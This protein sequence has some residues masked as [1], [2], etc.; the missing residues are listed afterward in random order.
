MSVSSANQ[1]ANAALQAYEQGQL[2]DA[3]ALALQALSEVAGDPRASEVMGL[4]CIAERRFVDAIRYL[5]EGLAVSPSN[6]SLRS[7]MGTALAGK[8]R[9]KTAI[10]FFQ[11]AVQAA[12]DDAAAWENLAKTAY[13][14]KRW[15]HA[16]AAFERCC[17]I[18]PTNC[19][20]WA[21]LARLN[22]RGGTLDQAI[23][24]AK[25]ALEIDSGHVLSQQAM[26]DAMLQTGDF[27]SALEHALAA[28]QSPAATA[29]SDVLSFGFAAAA[30]E[31]LGKFADAFDFYTKMNEATS[32][33]FARSIERL[34]KMG[35]HEKLPE[36]V[37]TI[38][39]VRALFE[40]FP[41]HL[42]H[43][44]PVMFFG[45]INSGMSMINK[46]LIRHPRITSVTK[47]E[48]VDEW[49]DLL[50]SKD[51]PQKVLMQS[52]EDVAYLREHTWKNVEAVGVHVPNENLGFEY[53]PFYSQHIY[54][55]AMVF[56]DSKYIFMHRDPRDVVLLSFKRRF[57]AT[58]S[59]QEFL[60]LER[61]AEYYDLAMQVV[62]ET[63]RHFDLDIIDVGYDNIITDPERELRRLVEFLE[64]PWDDAVLGEISQAMPKVTQAPKKWRQY[65]KQLEPV[66]PLLDKWAKRFG[67]E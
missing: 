16:R 57:T 3:E 26:A 7:L 33:G 27:D 55:V 67:Y 31:K 66:R 5:K 49:R 60:S 28:T 23:E 19:D 44:A 6:A 10:G 48:Y 53:R 24:M 29:K 45:F 41:Q 46:A 1:S 11:Q 54:S 38:P 50:T 64:L 12:P 62:W 32:E 2:R 34:E 17:E 56:P 13:Q 9:L 42:Q 52:P 15:D 18:D 47:H 21:G 65:E 59:M 25:R 37:R 63:R 14:L 61:A 36:V 22:L 35:M 4:V 51:A 20:A 43:S 8:G 40:E 39:A 58:V 30:S